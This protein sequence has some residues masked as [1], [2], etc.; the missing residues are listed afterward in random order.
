MNLADIRKRALQERQE[1]ENR[2]DHASGDTARKGPVQHPHGSDTEGPREEHP[3]MPG[4]R[5]GAVPAPEPVIPFDPLGVILAG[6]EAVAAASAATAAPAPPADEEETREFL[7]FT[8]GS[9]TYAMEIGRVKVIIRPRRVTVVPR[10]PESVA[11]VISHRGYI[12]PVVD[13]AQLLGLENVPVTGEER[14]IIVRT[15]KG[16]C[17]LHV[18][19]VRRVVHVPLAAIASPQALSG[20]QKRDFIEGIAWHRGTMLIILNL[21]KMIDI[22]A[23]SA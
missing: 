5:P 7:G 4:D 16:A 3:G 14:V 19:S 11:G 1:R 2:S 15:E 12:I 10:A 20:G 22:G 17:G 21:H 23:R 8:V 6:R 13:L 9:E 18:S